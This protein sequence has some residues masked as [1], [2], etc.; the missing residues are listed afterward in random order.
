MRRCNCPRA[1]RWCKNLWKTPSRTE[2]I[3]ELVSTYTGT[4]RWKEKFTEWASD[5]QHRIVG[6]SA[7]RGGNITQVYGLWFRQKFK[8][9]FPIIL[10]FTS[11]RT[12]FDSNMN[13]FGVVLLVLGRR[14]RRD[15]FST[16]QISGSF[17]NYDLDTFLLNN[18]SI[19]YLRD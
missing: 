5:S 19:F 10:D 8:I 3:P 2:L 16:P 17:K 14:F 9:W 15:V 7:G 12:I 13:I 11:G 6:K 4:S 18:M 1:I